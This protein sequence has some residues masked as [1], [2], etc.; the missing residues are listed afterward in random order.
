M[1]S[2]NIVFIPVSDNAAKLKAICD[3]ANSQFQAEKTLLIMVPNAQAAAYVDS[4]LWKSP[5]ESFLPHLITDN[6]TGE[7]C[8]IT[9][10]QVNV[11]KAAVVLNLC[12]EACPIFSEFETVFELWDET[13]PTKTEQSAQRKAAYA[14]LTQSSSPR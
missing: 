10:S 2:P 8:V 6:R 11:N 5:E 4:L 12:P 7:R 9:T 3:I 14:A 13:H 1:S